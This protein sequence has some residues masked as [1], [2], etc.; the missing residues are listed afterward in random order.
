MKKHNVWKLLCCLLLMTALI[1]SVILPTAGQS[2]TQKE[3]N[4]Q[5]A[6]ASTMSTPPARSAFAPVYSS[7]PTATLSTAPP[8]LLQSEAMPALAAEDLQALTLYPGGMPFGIKFYTDGVTVVGFCDVETKS[9]TV[10]PA[11]LAGL[12]IKDVILKVNGE[13]LTGANQLTDLIENSDGKP[14]TLHCRRGKDELDLTLTPVYCPAES[15]YKTGI[16]VRDCGAGIGTVTFILPDTGAFAGLGHGICDADTG[17]LISMRR[18][19]VSDVT[20]SSVVRGAAGAPGE[21]KGYFNAGKV[22]AL[23]GNSSC[24]VWGVFSEIPECSAE[25]MSVGLRDDLCEGDAYILCTLDTN[26]IE[27]YDV[28]ITNINRDSTGSKCFT[29]TVTDPD[30]LAV[31]GGIVQGMSGSPII[32][33]GKLVGAVTHVLINDPT[34]G[35]GIFVE[36]MLVNMPLM[37]R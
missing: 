36:N 34:T 15:R 35:Y 11:N 21:L 25:P 20:I 3:K 10:N 29:V 23:L 9:G 6:I 31:T 28:K 4:A 2:T 19:T 16:W 32:Q 17:A 13:A 37:A 7:I 18:G 5:R 8:V 22:G 26:K 27:R 30:L 1:L 24:G 14:L 12:R 33:N